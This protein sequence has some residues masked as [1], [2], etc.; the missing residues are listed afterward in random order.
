[1][2][3]FVGSLHVNGYEGFGEMMTCN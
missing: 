3:D 1:V 2:M